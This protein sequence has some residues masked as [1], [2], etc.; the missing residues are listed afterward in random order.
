M[1]I[2]GTLNANGTNEN[3]IYFTKNDSTDTWQGL[4]FHNGASGNLE[5]SHIQYVTNSNGYA[6]YT[7]ST[8]LSLDNCI[9]EN[10]DYGFYGVNQQTTLSNTTFQNTRTIFNL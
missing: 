7:D 1:D 5:Y 8:A 2:Y 10:N 6:I 4:N 3:E 9:I